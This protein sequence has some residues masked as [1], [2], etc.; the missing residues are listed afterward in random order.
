VRRGFTGELFYLL[1]KASGLNLVFS[2][3]TFQVLMYWIYLKNA[4]RLSINGSFS[5][6]KTAL[7]LSPAFVLFPVFDPYGAFRKEI[8]LFALY[9]VLCTHLVV[10]NRIHKSLPFLIGI[11]AI[12]MILS[13]E[14]LAIYLP[15]LICPIIYYEKGLGVMAKRTAVALVPAIAITFLLVTYNQPDGQA[16]GKICASLQDSAPR[17]CENSQIPGA[18]TFLSQNVA[19]AHEFVRDSAN[20]T[21]IVLYLVS[22]TLAFLPLIFMAFGQKHLRLNENGAGFWLTLCVGISVFASIPVFWV[23]ADYGRL[24]NIHVF[25]LSMLI[26]MADQITGES[27][28]NPSL[29]QK[30]SWALAVAFICGWRLV[31]WNATLGSTFPL[32]KF[33]YYLLFD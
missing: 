8:V 26:L 22:A 17:D 32:V 24:I 4:R 30:L 21:S 2:I 33:F 7:I 3:V 19:D 15:Y 11:S 18:I 29:N 16:I 5:A 13:H 31:H 25:C 28:T 12:C 6:L 20:R 9:S 27:I 23:A 10:T 1:S 14:M